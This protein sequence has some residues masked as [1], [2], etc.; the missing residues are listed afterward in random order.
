MPSGQS[1]T[2][3]KFLAQRG[4]GRH[5]VVMAIAREAHART[6]FPVHFRKPN[7]YESF[8]LYVSPATT[9]SPWRRKRP[10]TE[11]RWNRHPDGSPWRWISRFCRLD[12]KIEGFTA[13]LTGSWLRAAEAGSRNW[14]Y[15][16]RALLRASRRSPAFRNCQHGGRTLELSRGHLEAGMARRAACGI[17]AAG[18]DAGYFAAAAVPRCHRRNVRTGRVVSEPVAA[19]RSVLARAAGL[20]IRDRRLRQQRNRGGRSS[21]AMGGTKSTSASRVGFPTGCTSSAA[22]GRMQDITEALG[23]RRAGRFDGGAVSRSAQLGPAGSGGAH[24]C[25]AAPFSE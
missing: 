3:R 19:R 1:L 5:G 13:N 15:P 16:Q 11:A 18:R 23:R 12:T 14:A 8:A 4:G 24:H 10:D 2:R 7:P 20:G 21:T 9:R 17:R 25:R 22:D 6:V